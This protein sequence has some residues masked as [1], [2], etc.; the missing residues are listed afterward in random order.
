MK[1]KLFNLL[2]REKPAEM[3]LELLNA[4]TEVYSS[5][6]AKSV[7]CTYSHVVKTLQH[8]HKAGVI[9]FEKRGRLKI[10]TL[11]KK[12]EDIAR[13]IQRIKEQI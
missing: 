9:N 8:L 7:D 10:L 1:K 13:N 11:T 2:F 5:S 3:L 12:G 4:K 6:L